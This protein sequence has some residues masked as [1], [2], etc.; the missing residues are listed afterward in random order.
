MQ[1]RRYY[2]DAYTTQF[3][4]RI[5]ARPVIN[6]RPALVLDQTYFYPESGGQ[7]A[8]Q[9]QIN[10]Q[11]IV[12]VQIRPEDGAVL[13]FLALDEELWADTVKAIINWERRFDHMQQHTGQ[14]ILSQAFI[15]VA[16]AET[17]GF[18]LGT[19]AVTIDL[20]STAVTAAQIEQAEQ[21][22]NQIVWENR[23][24]HIHELTF[25]AAA[26]GLNG[27]TMRKIPPLAEEMVRVIEI[28]GFD[29][30]ACGGT[31]VRH[32]GEVGLIKIMRLE[33]RRSQL[34]V[35]FRCGQRALA[36]YRLKNSIMNRLAGELTTGFTELEQS[37]R[38]LKEELKSSQ[39]QLRQREKELLNQEADSLL[40]RSQTKD[41]IRLVKKVFT[42]RDPGQVRYLAG[43]IAQQPGCI[44]LLATVGQ[45]TQFIFAR[46]Q[47]A[48]GEMDQLLKVALQVVGPGTGGGRGGGRA[49]FAQGGCPTA[50]LERVEQ[51]ISR[52]ERLLWGRVA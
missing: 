12:D 26:L 7:P 13:H 9:G 8:D 28:K 1:T 15:Q 33:K 30:T 36:D 38:K 22:A 43:Q 41:Q 47:D 19:E 29:L 31:H 21:L 50:S 11:P 20:D 39:Q 48:P 51:A 34:R 45:P 14:H 46:A 2:Q 24:V 18:H 17:V 23:P 6:D 49:Q 40:A 32:T 27:L 3:Q 10:G 5:T 35:E 44:A 52:V 37:V 4:A 16:E 25:A 42:N